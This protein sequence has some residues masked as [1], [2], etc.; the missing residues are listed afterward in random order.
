MCAVA[1]APGVASARVWAVTLR[2]RA[3]TDRATAAGGRSVAYPL[4]ARGPRFRPGEASPIRTEDVAPTLL[5]L[6]GVPVPEAYEG[7]SALPTWEA[8]PPSPAPSPGARLAPG[9]T[10]RGPVCRRV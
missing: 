7:E 2:G 5:E 3:P 9:R 1:S 8:A 6:V 4:L 10:S